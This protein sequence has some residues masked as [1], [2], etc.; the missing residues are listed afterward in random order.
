ME[1]NQSVSSFTIES[2]L[3]FALKNFPEIDEA[4][5]KKEEIVKIYA[6][7]FRKGKLSGEKTLSLLTEERLIQIGIPIGHAAA[8][9]EA[10]HAWGKKKSTSVMFE[11]EINFKTNEESK[12][13]L[14]SN[15]F[16]PSNT[17][18]VTTTTMW[19]DVKVTVPEELINVPTL[20]HKSVNAPREVYIWGKG[21]KG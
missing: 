12:F 13:Q 19:P 4:N 8:I 14:S 11:T 1:Q 5:E 6:E 17:S 15:S 21:S 16:S 10:T 3:F 9:Y 18:V 2:F 7:K 20:S